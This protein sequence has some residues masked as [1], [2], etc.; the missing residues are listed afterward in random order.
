M[1]KHRIREVQKPVDFSDF[2]VFAPLLELAPQLPEPFVDEAKTLSSV[3]VV[4]V[5]PTP[6]GFA[7]YVAALAIK[8]FTGADGALR[9]R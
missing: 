2:L 8:K 1:S 4:E 5:S 7:N 9:V 6:D 3:L